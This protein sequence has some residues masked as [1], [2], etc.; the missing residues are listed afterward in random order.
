MVQIH[1]PRPLLL[2]SAILLHTKN[3]ESAWLET[4]RSCLNIQWA[5]ALFVLWVH[6]VATEGCLY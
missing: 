5:Q 2:E 4:K 3:P 1:S 6:C